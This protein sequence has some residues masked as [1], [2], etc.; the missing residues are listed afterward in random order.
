M[1]GIAR[2]ATK[3]N[4]VRKQGIPTILVDGG[5]FAPDYSEQGEIKL[6][7]LIESFRQ[8]EYDAISVG[9]R[10][11]LIQN[12]GYDAWEKLNTSQI[13]IATLNLKYRG[14]RL[15]DK[16]IIID[17]NGVKVGV[18]GLFLGDNI[19]GLVKQD[20]EIE[21]SEK[22]IDT[23]LPYVKRNSDLVIAMLHGKKPEVHRFVEKHIGMD[24]VIVSRYMLI[25]AIGQKIKDSILL[26]VGT[27]GKYLGRVDAYLTK[28]K[29]HF[30]PKLVAL[31]KKV[32][33]DPILAAT[34][35]GYQERVKQME[36]KRAE[37]LEEELSDKFPSVARATTCRNCHE[38]IYDKWVRA[39][40]VRA[41]DTL[42]EENEHH[43]PECLGC[44]TTAYLKGGF[45]SLGKTPDYTGVQC[46][47]CHGRLE[48]HIEFHSGKSEISKA[49]PEVTEDVCLKC[50][51]PKNDDDFDFER[52]RERVH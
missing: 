48:E 8:M 4:E 6:E 14:K 1:G 5:E 37:I 15:N 25:T 30:D 13:P 21:D 24:I 23:A 9:E 34:Y 16:P 47:S 12:Q 17:R 22:V 32:P 42:I 35:A 36:L 38:A 51:D 19:T 20:W 39:P 45:I 26:S 3:V 2:R 33:D 27:R 28:G 40:H 7:T 49:P 43:N 46:V 31:D 18:F 44:H 52:D 11:I 41:T 50:H 10:E 29:W